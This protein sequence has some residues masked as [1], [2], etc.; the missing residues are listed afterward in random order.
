MCSKGC[1]DTQAAQAL[2]HARTKKKRDTEN[3]RCLTWGR[4]GVSGVCE[5]LP[6]GVESGDG[7]QVD[8][9]VVQVVLRLQAAAHEEQQGHAHERDEHGDQQSARDRKVERVESGLGRRRRHLP[10]HCR[11]CVHMLNVRTRALRHMCAHA[12]DHE[13]NASSE[14]WAGA[15]LPMGHVLML[16]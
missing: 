2:P 9:G 5:G 14:D 7:S 15:V 16:P 13:R 12:E 1:R 4:G 3:V 8:L 11:R 6:G 10:C